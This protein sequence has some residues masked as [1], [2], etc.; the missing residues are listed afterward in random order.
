MFLTQLG[1]E[2]KVFFTS[3]GNLIF[4]FCMPILLITIFSFAL[5]DYMGGSYGTF[6]NAKVLYLVKDSTQF[7]SFENIKDNLESLGVTFEETTD[8][9][10]ACKDVEGSKAYG[11][12]TLEKEGFSYFRSDFNEP[13]GGKLVRTLFVQMA[14]D[15]MNS[16]DSTIQ[17][18]DDSDSDVKK[19]KLNVQ[20]FESKNYYTFAGLAFSI[21]FMGTTSCFYGL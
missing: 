11:V 7:S 4:M 13:E 16:A 14:G 20:H 5:K 3:K 1:K 21:M 12:I 8:Y 9:E 18:S 2:V 19:I 6:D 17:K 10:A 15:A